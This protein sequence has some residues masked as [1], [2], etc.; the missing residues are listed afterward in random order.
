MA[1]FSLRLENVTIYNA[2]ES[3]VKLVLSWSRERR[4]RSIAFEG[5]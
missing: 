2:Q 4:E 5:V 3:L 1:Y